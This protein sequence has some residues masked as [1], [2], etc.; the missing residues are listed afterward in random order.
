M[1]E[2]LRLRVIAMHDSTSSCYNYN[3]NKQT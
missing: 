2:T 3:R 1:K